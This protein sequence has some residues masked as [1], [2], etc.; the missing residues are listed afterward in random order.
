MRFLIDAQLPPALAR[1]LESRGH[2]SRPVREAGMREAKDPV[3]WSFAQQGAWVIVTK[4]ED[5][6]QRALTDRFGPQVLWLRIGNST[7][8]VLLAWLAPLLDDAVRELHAGNRVVEL[9]RRKT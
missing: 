8:P 7:T 9:Q 2:E 6:A 5:F 1:F 3:I 4:D